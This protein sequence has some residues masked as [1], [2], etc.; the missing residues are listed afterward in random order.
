MTSIVAVLV[1]VIIGVILGLVIGLVMGVA[2]V[3]TLT[4]RRTV[5]HQKKIRAHKP[6]A[7]HPYN[8]DQEDR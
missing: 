4:G 8:Y 7:V 6:P 1:G 3:I 5:E 2:L